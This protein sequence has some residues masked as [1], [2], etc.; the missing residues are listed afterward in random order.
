MVVG[1]SGGAGVGAS[2]KHMYDTCWTASVAPP[3]LAVL[4]HLGNGVPNHHVLAVDGDCT[5]PLV[6]INGKWLAGRVF[7]RDFT[8]FLFCEW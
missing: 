1:V 3:H 8:F 7:R 6:A 4:R 2:V 5:A